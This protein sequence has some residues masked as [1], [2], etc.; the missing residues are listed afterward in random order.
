MDTK[1]EITN[2]EG[3]LLKYEKVGNDYKFNVYKPNEIPTQDM[4]MTFNQFLNYLYSELYWTHS[5]IG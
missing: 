2:K 4:K 3:Y 5:S 1:G